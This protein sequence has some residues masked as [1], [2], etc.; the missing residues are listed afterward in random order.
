MSRDSEVYAAE[1]RQLQT[2]IFGTHFG[3]GQRT[4]RK[5]LRKALVGEKVAKYYPEPLSLSDP[6]FVDERVE[7]CDFSW[8]L[9]L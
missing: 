1:V 2:L 3:D 4:G 7:R 5:L 6:L 9:L 8:R